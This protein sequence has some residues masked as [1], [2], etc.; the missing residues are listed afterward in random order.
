M[1]DGWPKFEELQ[2]GDVLTDST[3]EVSEVVAIYPDGELIEIKTNAF[4]SIVTVP[5]SI[6]E[7]VRARVAHQHCRRNQ[8]SPIVA[9][10]NMSSQTSHKCR[11][12]FRS[13]LMNGCQ[14]GG[15]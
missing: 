7:A 2:I 6:Y 8:S 13:L 1:S 15:V 12:E 14:C 3:P 5:R 11:C 4:T 10:S 9:E